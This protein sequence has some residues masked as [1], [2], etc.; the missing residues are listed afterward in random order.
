[1]CA[2]FDS[3]SCFFDLLNYQKREIE[4]TVNVLLNVNTS[5]L[6]EGMRICNYNLPTTNNDFKLFLRDFYTR[7]VILKDFSLDVGPSQTIVRCKISYDNC[8]IIS[9]PL[10]SFPN[11][12]LQNVDL[13]KKQ[14]RNLS[15]S[16]KITKTHLWF[17]VM[18]SADIETDIR[19]C[20]QC[21]S[22]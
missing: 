7:P 14:L 18:E 17:Q 22:R 11:Q 20:L 16:Y 6:E 8:S 5:L 2:A 12:T 21:Y 10:F 1:M 15:F 3:L 19:F 4:D 9:K 13:I